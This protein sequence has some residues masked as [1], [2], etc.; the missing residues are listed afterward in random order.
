MKEGVSTVRPQTES[1]MQPLYPIEELLGVRE[2]EVNEQEGAPEEETK[3]W[4]ELAGK[5][6][7]LEE[8]VARHFENEDKHQEDGPP[9][10]KTPA[11]PTKGEYDKHQVT[12][13]PFAPWCRHCVAAR[14]AR[15]GHPSKGRN[16][17]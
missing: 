1:Q 12:H 4:E 10:V 3:K 7:E 5:C 2:A 17:I 9:M 6:T 14:A 13:T 8:R 11:T 15:D 16:V